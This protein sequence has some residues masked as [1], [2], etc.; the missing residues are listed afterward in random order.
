MQPLYAYATLLYGAG[1]FL[2]EFLNARPD[3]LSR[4]EVRG[5][6]D[7]LGGQLLHAVGFHYDAARRTWSGQTSIHGR[8]DDGEM[9]IFEPGRRNEGHVLLIAGFDIPRLSNPT[10]QAALPLTYTAMRLEPLSRVTHVQRGVDR[11]PLVNL[12]D[13]D[14]PP[15]QLANMFSIAQEMARFSLQMYGKLPMA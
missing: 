6:L 9:R 13:E 14:V 11:Y 4:R 3:E 7:M 10:M 1:M 8:R 12:A 15:E 5:N 2:A